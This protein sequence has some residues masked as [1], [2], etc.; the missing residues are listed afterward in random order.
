[1]NDSECEEQH[2]L[3]QKTKRTMILW[4]VH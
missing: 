3:S 4:G 1:V 2:V